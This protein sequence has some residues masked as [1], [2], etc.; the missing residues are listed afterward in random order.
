MTAPDVHA[1][2]M[3]DRVDQLMYL[4]TSAAQLYQP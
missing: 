3:I 2:A 1:Q 4:C